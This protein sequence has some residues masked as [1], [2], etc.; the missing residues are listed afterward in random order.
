[1]VTESAAQWRE[2]VGETE[3]CAVIRSTRLRLRLEASAAVLAAVLAVV[4]AAALA[5][6]SAAPAAGPSASP[7]TPGPSSSAPSASPTASPRKPVTSPSTQPPAADRIE[8]DVTIKDGKVDPSGKKLD[9]ALGTTVVLN[10]TSDE[11][12]EIH[13]HI[14]SGDGYSLEVKAGQPA[15]GQFTMK[16][17][18]SF[19]VESHHLEK[20]IVI[21]NVR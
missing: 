1:M 11:D 14:G 7:E 20:I 15:R 18:G 19:D 6:C 10:V 8:I 21:L 16:D 3:G 2:A 13:A 5:A 9:V 17:S 12:D 4:L